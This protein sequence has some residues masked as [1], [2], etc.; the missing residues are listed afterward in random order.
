MTKSANDLIE[1]IPKVSL[2]LCL[3]SEVALIRLF[4]KRRTI[5]LKSWEV[6]QIGNGNTRLSFPVRT[7][8]KSVLC[9]FTS[10]ELR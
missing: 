3:Y 10:T 5:W 7:L 8:L 4:T 1:H 9:R 2:P 6:R